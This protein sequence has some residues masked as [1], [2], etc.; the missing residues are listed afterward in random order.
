MRPSR[1][2]AIETLHL[3]FDW[4]ICNLIVISFVPEGSLR[5]GLSQITVLS[6]GYNKE[7]DDSRLW[8]LSEQCSITLSSGASFSSPS[9]VHANVAKTKT[10]FVFRFAISW[11]NAAH[12]A[13]PGRGRGGRQGCRRPNSMGYAK[14][15][16]RAV[17][18]PG[19]PNYSFDDINTISFT[20]V[21]LLSHVVSAQMAEW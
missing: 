9:V 16:A 12:P 4:L 14:I 1:N 10:N 15:L 5:V 11:S 8:S 3:E 7:I 6:R 18:N 17:S 2:T 21:T 20:T 19:L 13:P